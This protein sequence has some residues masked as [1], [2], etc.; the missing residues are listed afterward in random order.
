MRLPRQYLVLAT[1]LSA[2]NACRTEPNGSAA[3]IATNPT[4]RGSA[5]AVASTLPRATTKPKVHLSEKETAVLLQRAR[6]HT[7]SKQYAQAIAV[8][9]QILEANDE[10]AQA[11][12]ERGYAYFRAEQ[13]SEA[14]RDF[15]RARE[16]A[17]DNKLLAQINHNERL[18]KQAR[19]AKSPPEPTPSA[20]AKPSLAPIDALTPGIRCHLRALP[21]KDHP[22]AVKRDSFAEAWTTMLEAHRRE[23]GGTDSAAPPAVHVVPESDQSAVEQG[24]LHGGARLTG[25]WVVKLSDETDNSTFH[26]LFAHASALVV[27]PAVGTAWQTPRFV[28]GTSAATLRKPGEAYYAVALDEEENETGHGCWSKDSGQRVDC[29]TPNAIGQGYAIQVARSRTVYL[30]DLQTFEL[31]GALDGR[32]SVAP[33]KPVRLPDTLP[34]VLRYTALDATLLACG[35]EQRLTWY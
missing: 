35:R 1:V 33:D 31:H 9:S 26:L 3:A 34:F 28:N 8:F 12:A 13:F 20:T 24:L 16:L 23:M 2:V 6:R 18:L 17:T 4:P 30:I 19:D 5:S 25:G 15:S 14:R 11:T 29:S 32:L 22:K 7:V 27:Y 10:H 21:K